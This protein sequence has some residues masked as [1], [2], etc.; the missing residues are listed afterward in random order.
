MSAVWVASATAARSD[1]L[2]ESDRHEAIAVLLEGIR[3]DERAAAGGDGAI[4]AA[5]LLY[6]SPSPRDS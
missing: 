1:E 5:C 3:E 4:D 6:T 2:A